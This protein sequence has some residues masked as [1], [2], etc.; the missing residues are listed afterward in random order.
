MAANPESRKQ[1]RFMR[2]LPWPQLPFNRGDC[3][4]RGIVR[5]EYVVRRECQ[6]RRAPRAAAS[7]LEKK[8]L[9]LFPIH[10]PWRERWDCNHTY[11]VATPN[12]RPPPYLTPLTSCKG[13]TDRT[14]RRSSVRSPP[15]TAP[16]SRRRKLPNRRTARLPRPRCWPTSKRVPYQQQADNIVGKMTIAALDREMIAVDSRPKRHCCNDCVQGGGI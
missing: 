16:S 9:F 4:R 14:W 7:R 12:S 13:R 1:R 8:R 5:G 2:E 3:L 10:R 11:S 6:V 15:L